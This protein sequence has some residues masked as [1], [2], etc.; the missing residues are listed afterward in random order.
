MSD[1]RLALARLVSENRDDYARW[2]TNPVA[3]FV[4]THNKDFRTMSDQEAKRVLS[5]QHG[6][7]PDE[8][9]HPS[10]IFRDPDFLV[11]G[12]TYALASN[13]YVLGKYLGKRNEGWDIWSFE[14]GDRSM[15][16]I[17]F[18]LVDT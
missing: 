6:F 10:K 17:N 11:V 9:I 15:D 4:L 16:N 14:T 2:A 18:Y 13:G 1:E 5:L 7:A 12:K 8:E 3:L